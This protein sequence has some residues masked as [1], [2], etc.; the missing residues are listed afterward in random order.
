MQHLIDGIRQAV[1][2]ESWYAAL[3]LAL[4][5]PDI[6]GWIET[7]G[8]Q[9]SR[10]RYTRWFNENVQ[11]RYTMPASRFMPEHVFLTG[12]DC[13]ALRCAFLHEG[14]FDIE[15]ARS[16]EVLERFRFVVL[17][18]A[19]G[20]SIHRNQTNNVLQLGVAEFCED[21]CAAVEAWMPTVRDPAKK[22]RLDGLPRIELIDF[23]KPVK[24]SL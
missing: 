19:P 20:S 16:Q 17:Q 9:N 21:I 5:L 18:N 7:P 8:H 14:D 12:G 6:C 23:S 11:P 24:F 13:F 22:T 15:G 3:G 1:R 2:T 4:A 10:I